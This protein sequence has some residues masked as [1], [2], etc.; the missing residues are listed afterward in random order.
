[1]NLLGVDR[2]LVLACNGVSQEVAIRMAAGVARLF[3]ADYGI[4][5]TGY[6]EPQRPESGAA[7]PS[8]H[9]YV[10]IYRASDA[11]YRVNIVRGLTDPARNGFRAEVVTAALHM[12]AEAGRIVDLPEES[13]QRD[14]VVGLSGNPVQLS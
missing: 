4:A 13:G 8:Q 11:S 2:E 7:E 12:W 5:T 6:A 1:M 9:A 3:R 14:T 10:A